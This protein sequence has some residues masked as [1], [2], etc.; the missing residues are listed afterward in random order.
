[1]AGTRIDRAL[2]TTITGFQTPGALLKLVMRE[3]TLG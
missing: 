3:D 2:T 1:M